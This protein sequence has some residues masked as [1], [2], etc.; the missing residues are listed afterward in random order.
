MMILLQSA[1]ALLLMSGPAPTPMHQ[2]AAPRVDQIEYQGDPADS[3]FKAARNARDAN[4][5]RK[6]ATIYQ[7][8]VD[9]Y[10]KSQYAGDALY[11][12]GWS[13]WKIG[14]ERRSRSDLDGAL[15]AINKQQASYPNA[16]MSSDGKDLKGWITADQAK[17]GDPDAAKAMSSTAQELGTRSGCP[18]DDDDMRMAALNG[19]LQTDAESALP[20]LKAVLAKRGACTEQLR[21][22][23]VFILS[24][25]RV[26]EATTLLLDAARN[27][28]SL[29]VRK[30]AVQ[31]L[32]QTRSDRAAAALDSILFSAGDAEMRNAAI[33]ALS[34]Q[35][36]PRSADALRRAAAD[37]KLPGE[38][39]GQA[40][41]W[42][43]Q[44]RLVDLAFFRDLFNKKNTNEEMRSQILMAV[45]QMR[46]PEASAWLLE[47]ARDKS[48][49]EEARKNAIFQASQ[50]R[51]VDLDGLAKLYDDSKG[52]EEIQK[53]ILFV[54][55]QRREPAALDKLMAVART[56]TNKEL[57]KQA[58]FWIGQKAKYDPRAQAFLMEI[59]K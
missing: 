59:L 24:Q 56:D 55:S 33:F 28:P 17:L 43:G 42:L 12:R 9:R 40:I 41:F 52:E 27:D 49:D 34:Q 11:W 37:E 23:A 57:K 15:A 14:V 16:S 29:D 39:R 44:T 32:G 54:Y 46:S 47:L 38:V 35:R 13:L 36:S 19:L 7:Q 48:L 53:Q 22:T 50:Q 2:I 21:K 3:L 31:W 51:I 26:D 4:D 18:S 58:I 1:A 6:A 20:I 30:D 25:K 5:L 8:L 45:S 10:P